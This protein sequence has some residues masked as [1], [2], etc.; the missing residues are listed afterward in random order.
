MITIYH[1]PRCGKSREALKLLENS[2]EKFVVR[3]YLKNPLSVEELIALNKKL[4]IPP[5]AMI[6][7]GEEIFKEKYKNL[8]LSD[9]ELLVAMAQ[10]PILMERAIVE[11][12]NV[13]VIARPPEKALTIIENI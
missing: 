6:R 5:L 8:R 13:A 12:E 1:N 10:Y 2:G 9:H 11:N 4:N 3:E 7:Q